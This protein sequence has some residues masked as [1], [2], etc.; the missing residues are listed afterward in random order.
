MSCFYVQVS[1]CEMFRRRNSVVKKGDYLTLFVDPQADY[2]TVVR[3][4]ALLLHLVPERCN[5][6]HANG[7]KIIEDDIEECDGL[8][9][10]SIGRYL[11]SRY[12]KTSTYKL[13]ILCEERI[14]SEV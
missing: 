4:G 3:K 8:Y 7:S 14:S 5:L 2:D 1:I 11:R 9:P 6:C 10:W 12:A 13:G